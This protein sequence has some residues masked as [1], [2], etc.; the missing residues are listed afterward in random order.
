MRRVAV[1]VTRT[2]LTYCRMAFVLQVTSPEDAR[3]RMVAT[4]MLSPAAEPVASPKREIVAY[5]ELV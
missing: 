3:W 5:N 2:Q 1:L 4:I